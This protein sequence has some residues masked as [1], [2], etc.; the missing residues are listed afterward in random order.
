MGGQLI[1]DLLNIKNYNPD[2]FYVSRNNVQ[3]SEVINIWP[4][5]FNNSAIIYGRRKS[6]KTHL[7]NIWKKK[8]NAE[9]ID[10]DSQVHFRKINIKRNL[11]IDNFHNLSGSEEENFFHFYNQSINKKYYILMLI[12]QDRSPQ[13]QL[14]DLKS[15][16]SS[17]TSATIEDPDDNLVN[18]LIVKFFQ[19]QQIIV[20]PTVVSF[21]VKR[22][23]RNYEAIDS[24]LKKI[25]N[26]SIEKKSKIS[27]SFLNK[28]FSF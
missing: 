11:I 19:D 4:S 2:D 27:I 3:A 6:G 9:F 18:A 8:A 13:I 17:C 20:D 5:W 23:E 10:L 1:F 24:F 12:D 16:I 26:L 25:D 22:I 21:I 14:K 15:R 7:A 28:F